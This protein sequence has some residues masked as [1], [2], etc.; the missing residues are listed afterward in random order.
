MSI[1]RSLRDYCYTLAAL[2]SKDILSYLTFVLFFEIQL[3]YHLLQRSQ[4]TS[5]QHSGLGGVLLLNAPCPRHTPCTILLVVL[6][7]LLVLASCFPLG[8]EPTEVRSCVL[9]CYMV[10]AYPSACL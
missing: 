8:E 3:E 1:P 10:L 7:C 5:Q 2:A 6:H 9:C 4:P